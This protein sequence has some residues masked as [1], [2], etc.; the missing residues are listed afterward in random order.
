MGLEINTIVTLDT[1][2]KYAILKETIFQGKKYFLTTRVDAFKNMISNDVVILTE[3]H[4]GLDIYV[5]MVINSELR[6]QLSSL[7]ETQK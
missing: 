7:L 6:N 4:E 1:H 3:E 5:R 2:E